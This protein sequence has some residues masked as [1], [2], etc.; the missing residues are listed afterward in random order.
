M[1]FFVSVLFICGSP[2]HQS[3]LREKGENKVTAAFH[4]EAVPSIQQ[5]VEQVLNKHC[6][7]CS[8][9]LAVSLKVYVNI[10]SH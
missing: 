10:L 9:S 2:V 4:S 5:G 3:V 6:L 8:Q 1:I 7:D